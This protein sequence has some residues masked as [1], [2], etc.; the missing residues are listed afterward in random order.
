MGI[1]E[2]KILGGGFAGL[3]AAKALAGLA[4]KGHCSITLID[5]QQHTAMIPALPDYAAGLLPD[6]WIRTPIRSA[7]PAAVAFQLASVRSVDLRNKTI[8]TDA[9]TQSYDYLIDAL[10]SMACP[11]PSGW[12]QGISYGLATLQDAVRLRTALDTYLQTALKPHV[13]IS[14]AGYT[15]VELAI[16]LAR[17][18]RRDA[19]DMHV[20]LVE[21]AQDILTFLPAKQHAH[22]LA[23][24]AR[25][26]ITCKTGCAVDSVSGNDVRL[27]DGSTY[28][29]AMVC[30][31]IGTCAPLTPDALHMGARKDG[32]L[33]VKPDL[34]LD[35]ERS[36]F[37]AGDAA[38]I[39]SAKGYIRKAVNFSIYSGR[40]AGR[41]VARCIRGRNTKTFH[42]IDLGWVIPL[43]DDSVGT[44]LGA[45]PL[46]GKAGLALHYFMCGYRNRTFQQFSRF[47]GLAVRAITTPKGKDER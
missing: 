33:H 27:S 10:G 29:D 11:A 18:A 8:A 28:S 4:R 43:G 14:G 15:G 44:A 20:I 31:T 36:A 13:I 7:L 12:E 22:A 35:A 32:R 34:S 21:M 25:H 3:A 9:G 41:N 40:T 46:V 37:A 26:G 47:A 42:P 2:V 23:S 39:S 17:R 19:L 5:Q 24:L 6:D 30:R 38:A 16:S 1:P 45:C